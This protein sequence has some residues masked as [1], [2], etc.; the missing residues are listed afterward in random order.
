MLLSVCHPSVV[1]TGKHVY[2]TQCLTS[3]HCSNRETCICYLVFVIHPLQSQ[4]NIDML[5]SI[6]HP[7]I[8]VTGKH[9]YVTQ[10][11]SSIHC[12]RRETG[13][14]YSVFSIYPLQSQGKRDMLLSV[15]HPSVVEAGKKLYNTYQL[16]IWPGQI[17]VR[18][19]NVIE[20]E[21]SGL[22]IQR[23]SFLNN[24]FNN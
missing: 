3:I 7:S 14:C 2:V 16:K 4:G 15:C 5:L 1:V 22:Y 21:K 9:V 6:C 11:L 24:L 13:I 23:Y 12:S 20:I 10:C 8:V 17:N 19:Q 18:L